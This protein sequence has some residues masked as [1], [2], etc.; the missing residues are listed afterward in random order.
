MREN[1]EWRR[2]GSKDALVGMDALIWRLGTLQTDGENGNSAPQNP[3][4][5][6]RWDFFRQNSSV[7]ILVLSFSNEQ[8]KDGIKSWVQVGADGPW[9]PLQSQVVSEIL[10]HLPTPLEN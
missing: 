3:V 6:M 1:E 5:L 9:F 10:G 7:P 8:D 2:N 4:R